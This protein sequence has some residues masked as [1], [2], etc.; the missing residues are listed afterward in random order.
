[1]AVQ[2]FRWGKGGTAKAEDLIYFLWKRKLKSSN[3]AGF[4]T[5]QKRTSRY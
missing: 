5:P 2:E 3:G 1:V 4:F